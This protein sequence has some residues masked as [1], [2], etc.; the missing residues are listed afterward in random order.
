MSSRHKKRREN[1]QIRS[2]RASVQP[3]SRRKLWFFRGLIVAL[4]L[5]LL[6]LLELALRIGGFGFDPD[7]FSELAGADGQTYLTDN[8]A[9]SLSFFPPRLARWP[10]SFHIAKLKPAGVRRIYIFGESAAMGDPQPAYGASRYLEVLLRERF[11]DQSFEVVNLGITAVD[12]HVILPIAREVA[13]RGQGDLWIIYMGN[14][15]MIGPFGAATVFGSRA[16]P[17]WAARLNLAIQKWRVGQLATSLIHNLAGK[18]DNQPVWD[19]L[20]MFQQN[21]IAPEDPRRETVYRN[22]EGNLRDILKAAETAGA[23]VILCTMAVNLRDCPPFASIAATNQAA[24]DDEQFRALWNTALESE[25]Q[26]NY[27]AAAQSYEQACAL[28]PGFAEAH[29][30]WGECLTALNETDAAMK[31]FQLACDDDG[32]PF[33]A[34]SRINK[35]IR[36]VARE[37]STTKLLLC[38]AASAIN[39]ASPTGIAGDDLFFEHVHFNF[40]GN[41]RLAMNWADLVAQP[42]TDAPD[43]AATNGWASQAECERQLGLTDFNRVAVLQTVIRR[44]EAPPLNA[45][46]NNASRSAALK[47]A[48]GALQPTLHQPEA[49]GRARDL[50]QTAIAQSPNDHYLYEAMGNIS[51]SVGDYSGAAAAYQKS[52]SLEPQDFYS[53][54]RLGHALGLLGAFP[55]ATTVLKQA[56]ALRPSLP[57]GWY[58]LATV[59]MLAGE[60]TAALGNYDRACELQPADPKSRYARCRCQGKLFDRQNQPDKAIEQFRRA[61]EI[62]PG[63]WEAH[64]ELGGELDAANQLAEAAKEFGEAARLNPNYSR[65][66]LNYAVVLAKQNRLEEAQAEL[67]TTLRLE[68]QN[69]KAQDYLRQIQSLRKSQH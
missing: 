32:L 7:F 40:D 35:I 53:L 47:A 10:G 38:D 2:S 49:L 27:S 45:Q 12:S 43:A 39:S 46:L 63:N 65:T 3:M 26:S 9:F 19:G 20:N 41:Y 4:P 54:L 17:L 24:G 64:F 62:L 14:N 51:E 61:I 33:R 30:R 36:N 29:F 59:Q 37:S 48:D 42:M 21:Q 58:E 60:N 68:P 16:P 15:E 23:R 52:V 34:D 18:S 69:K 55:N 25:S 57:D 44:M 67:V 6:L 13:A 8:P 50:I 28:D 1:P 11:K 56:A 66:H 22:F 5:I 31:Q